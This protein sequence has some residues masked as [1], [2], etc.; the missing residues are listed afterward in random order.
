M[1]LDISREIEVGRPPGEVFDY[2]AHGEN[3]PSWMDE[4]VEVRQLSEGPPARGTTYSYKMK[5]GADS[6]FEWTQFEPSRKLAWHG[7][8]AGSGLAR[9]EPQG[10]WTLEP[11]GGG[12][13]VR[14]TMNPELHGIMKLFGPVMARQI[15]KGSEDDFQRLKA[16]IERTAPAAGE[17]RA[18]K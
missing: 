7:P 8:P 9:V 6:T 16:N 5:R 15:R 3:M 2:L 12:T 14:M 4:F 17:T 11:S 10:N 18:S 13:L 1:A